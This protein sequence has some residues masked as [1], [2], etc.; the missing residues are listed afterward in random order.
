MRAPAAP[1]PRA[2]GRRA[3]IPVDPPGQPAGV[4][5]GEGFSASVIEAPAFV[6]CLD[7]VAMVGQTIKQR[8]GHLGAPEHRG[9]LFEVEIGG[10]NDRGPFV[11]AADEVEEQLAAGLSEWQVAQ[12]V[13]HDQID[14]GELFGN[15]SSV[16]CPI[17]GL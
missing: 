14:A 2:G 17:F 11:E 16:S 4:G 1:P 9:P 8:G 10:N 15:L 6:A 12:F 5:S 7:D 13:E 3:R